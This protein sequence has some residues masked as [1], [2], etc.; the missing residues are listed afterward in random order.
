VQAFQSTP[1]WSQLAEVCSFWIT[2]N[3]ER[4]RNGVAPP[5]HPLPHSWPFTTVNGIQEFL[6]D[7]PCSASLRAKIWGLRMKRYGFR[8]MRRINSVPTSMNRHTGLNISWMITRKRGR[9]KHLRVCILQASKPVKHSGKVFY[10]S[11]WSAIPY[12]GNSP[13]LSG[14]HGAFSGSNFMST[15]RSKGS[16][17]P[18]AHVRNLTTSCSPLEFA[19]F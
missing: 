19:I 10:C 5:G 17:L 14:A 8:E 18:S 4:A 16:L 9:V 1:R 2:L 13:C 3:Y 11:V 15:S 6:V 7:D 12:Q